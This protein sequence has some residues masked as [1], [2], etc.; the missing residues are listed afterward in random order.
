MSLPRS[1]RRPL[2]VARRSWPSAAALVAALAGAGCSIPAAS[3]A[4]GWSA[5][6]KRDG[7]AAVAAWRPLAEDGD[8][9]AQY[10]IGLVL[11]EGRGVP[12]DPAEAARWY[13]RA[14]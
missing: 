14:A 1:L 2:A 13:R 3:L 5:F 9:D 7:A 4:D 8:P 6:E 10:L 11:D 12:A